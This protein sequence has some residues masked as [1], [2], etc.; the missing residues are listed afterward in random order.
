MATLSFTILKAK[1]T[2][3]NKFPVLLRISAKKQKAYIK[4]EYQLNDVSE[5]YNGKVVARTDA[6]MMNKRLAFELKKYTERLSYIENNDC[7]TASQLKMILIQQE[8]V[9]P[10]IITFNDFM[11]NRIKELSSEGRES[12]AKMNEDTLKV[13]EAA[14]GD[15]PMIIM[16]HITIEHFDR[17]MKANNYSDG[18]RQ[19]RLCHIKARIN[20]AIKNGLLRCEAHPFAYTKLPTPDIK[21]IDISVESVRKIINCDV[22]H[23]KRLS[24]AKD[25]FLLSFYLGGINF[26]DLIQINFSENDIEYKRQKSKDHKRKNRATRLN[27]I[28]EVR[29]IINKYITPN[30]MLD[31]G[32]SYTQKN[33]QC[34]INTCMKLLAK[35]LHIENSLT[36]YSARKTFAQF[37]AEIGIP[38]PV[39]EYCLGHSI[40]TGIT[41]NVYVKVKQ[42]Q[43]DAAIKRVV[44]YVQ[45]PAIFKDYINLRA[46][47]QMMML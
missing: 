15:V 23:S 25:L 30:G 5:W 21:E 4:T 11:R 13:F 17:W 46:Q 35:E 1:P 42:Q 26:A 29:Q 20:E 19:I 27:I 47:M 28:P 6:T 8:N 16:N 2:T 39:I 7:Y 38:Y 9:V 18:G 14:E 34:Y 43:A 40:K 22:S 3:E 33:L 41:I 44:E 10:S 36:Y 37:A 12:Y 24:L 32:Y 45:N 31:F